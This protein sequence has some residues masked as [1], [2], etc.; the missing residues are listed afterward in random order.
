MSFDCQTTNEVKS[1]WKS[2]KPRKEDD[3]NYPP[4]ERKTGKNPMIKRGS[5]ARFLSFSSIMG[6][7]QVTSRITCH[8]SGCTLNGHQKTRSKLKVKQGLNF[9]CCGEV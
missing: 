7:F 8:L 1:I 3:V 2:V 6:H 5:G 9:E 4:A